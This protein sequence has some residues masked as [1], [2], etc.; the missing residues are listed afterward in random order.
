MNNAVIDNVIAR[1]CKQMGIAWTFGLTARCRMA[2]R[3]SKAKD[4]DKVL[5][6]LERTIRE[7]HG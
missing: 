2:L 1:V 7:W 3:R 6:V 4:R 5:K